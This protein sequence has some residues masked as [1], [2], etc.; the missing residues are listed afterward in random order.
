VRNLLLSILCIAVLAGILVAG[1][2]PFHS[3]RNEVTWLKDR[4]GLHFGDY[5]TVM[6]TSALDET[7]SPDT[8]SCSIELWLQP[9]TD[10]GGT[11]LSFYA[12][13]D[14]LQLSLHQSDT[15]LVLQSRMSSSPGKARVQRIYINNV[16]LHRRPVFVTI[17]SA[18]QGTVVYVDGT[19]P[20]FVTIASAVQG[21]AV[22]ITGTV[23]KRGRGLQLAP[24]GC[25]GRII[26]GDSPWRHGTWSGQVRGLAIY[27]S[28]LTAS[29]VRRH[30]D[31]WTKMGK[32]DIA[33]QDRTAAL[34]LFDERA[35]N[36]VHNHARAGADL[37][38]PSTYTVLDKAF[39]RPDWDQFS[40]LWGYWMNNLK[41]VVGFVP[42]G[43]FFCAYFELVRNNK[44]AGL[45]TI[46]FGG[47]VSLTIEV[48]QG[49]LPTRDSGT[50]DLITN[51]FGTWI[52]VM[53]YNAARRQWE[54][55]I[56][57]SEAG[58]RGRQES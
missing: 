45:I 31:I 46:I 40:M 7:R 54:L 10:N 56:R 42:L 26:V 9:A 1:L 34:Y 27:S 52:G 3:P 48:L 36:M 21:A 37:F 58:Q 18:S 28:E 41:N 8:R 39:L 14:P 23:P 38:I 4:N 17:T 49:Y 11:I 53:L 19:R 6:S 16:F 15:D 44:R 2:W 50:T 51:T 43:S 33:E 35:G 22:Y 25:T 29:T 32:P 5:A 30:Y 47:A 20:V 55:H 12:P 57:I 13:D 24:D